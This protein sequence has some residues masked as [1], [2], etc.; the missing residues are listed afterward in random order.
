MLSK[1]QAES[2]SESLLAS[3]RQGQLQV[4]SRV[5]QARE[6]SV[7]ARFLVCA[8]T[9]FSVGGIFGQSQADAFFPACIAGLVCGI[10]YACVIGAMRRRREL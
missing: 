2:R 5:S 9:G 3:G 4:A 6:I 1:E 7:L 8:A 10:S